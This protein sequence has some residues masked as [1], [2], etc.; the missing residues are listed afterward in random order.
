MVQRWLM[1]DCQ[2]QKKTMRIYKIIFAAALLLTATGFQCEKNE[3][4]TPCLKAKVIDALCG[5]IILQ[6]IEGQYDPRLV[7]STWTDSQSGA[8]YSNVFAVANYCEFLGS[9]AQKGDTVSFR[10]SP[11]PANNSCFICLATR[12]T[13]DKKNNIILNTCQ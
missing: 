3:N 8:A 5:D 7:S 10:F 6:I 4:V 2:P 11:T 13:P 1:M 12:P 9:G